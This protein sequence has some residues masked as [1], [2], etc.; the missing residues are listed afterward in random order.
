MAVT[1]ITG[2]STGIGLTTALH[3]ARQGHEVYATMRDP[4]G[5]STSLVDTA[6]K[7]GLRINVAQ[8][9]VND[10]ASVNRAVGEVLGGA[11]RIDVLVNNA[12]IGDL[13]VIEHTTDAAARAMFETNVFGVLR[14]VRAVLP[15]MRD[16][17]S[18]TIV[19]VSSVAAL[20]TGFGSGLYSGTKR[21]L[22]G[23]SE[24]LALEV[25]KFG[26][27][28][29]IIEPGFFATP[30]IDKALAALS[31]DG[32]SP[33]ADVERRIRDLYAQ[34]MEAAADPQS[35]AEVIEHA[36][37]TDEPKL[38][39]LVG[40]DAPIFVDGR[41]RMSDEEYIE[42]GRERTDEDYWEE[43]QQRFPMPVQA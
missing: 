7:E 23:V 6:K 30:I 36:A 33:Y 42:M 41:R 21:A 10:P 8:L 38:R 20:I 43:F 2:T 15:G 13:S 3:F 37:T 39:Y 16:R 18:G 27:R 17:R 14:M 35:V 40:D 31:S 22:E 32:A 28:V 4:D 5:G 34:G 26:I 19:N 1:L 9:D 29:A 11:G 24:A 12:G 25:R